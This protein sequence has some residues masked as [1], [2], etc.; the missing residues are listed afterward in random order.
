MYSSRT[1]QGEIQPTNHYIFYGDLGPGFASWNLE[2]GEGPAGRFLA[3]GDPNPAPPPFMVQL[4]LSD[5]IGA[6]SLS[7]SNMKK[8]PNPAERCIWLVG[9][10]HVWVTGC[11][12]SW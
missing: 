12:I 8:K 1:K 4:K 5:L 2:S 3:K 10:V 7:E 9:S 6:S 11:N